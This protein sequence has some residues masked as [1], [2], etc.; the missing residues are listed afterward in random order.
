MPSIAIWFAISYWVTGYAHIL[1]IDQT[2]NIILQVIFTI[3]WFGTLFLLNMFWDK[4]SCSSD[5]ASH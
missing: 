1:V 2:I 5:K 4:I 3:L